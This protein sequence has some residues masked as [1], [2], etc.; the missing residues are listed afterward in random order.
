MRSA[1][2]AP[3]GTSTGR[4]R[5]SL[6]RRVTRARTEEA[7]LPACSKVR[8]EPAQARLRPGRAKASRL[9][10][11]TLR[12]IK[13]LFKRFPCHRRQTDRLKR[14][15]SNFTSSLGKR[16]RV[17]MRIHF[18]E[19]TRSSQSGKPTHEQN[20][21]PPTANS[22]QER[23]KHQKTVVGR[24]WDRPPTSVLRP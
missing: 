16:E 3:S 17:A 2:K 24:W 14:S 7:E 12:S 6:T 21:N 11:F 18:G 5:N 9:R 20:K 8:C 22:C 13:L 10:A 19:P 23:A 15:R 1:F 4:G